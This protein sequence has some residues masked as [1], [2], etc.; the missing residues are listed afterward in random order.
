MFNS[1]V[2]AIDGSANASRALESAS[3]LAAGDQVRLG[4]IYVIELD[5]MRLPLEI[6]DIGEIEHVI[7]P[8]P[9]FMIDLEKTSPDLAN[10]L[11]KVEADSYQALQQYADCLLTQALKIARDYGAS[12]V[13]VKAGQGDPAEMVVEYANERNADLI[14]SGSRGL[15]RLKQLLLGS[16]SHKINQL[17]A[18]SCLTVK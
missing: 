17:A 5:H 6:R 9:N 12:D 18:C 16:T 4:I 10:K 3:R 1:I 8:L 7:E 13:E 11:A 15:G 2:V 14:V